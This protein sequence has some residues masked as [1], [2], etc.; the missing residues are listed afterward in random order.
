MKGTEF[1]RKLRKLGKA[2][3]VPV[4]YANTR[5][6]GRGSHGK[7][8]YRPER[9]ILK[10]PKKELGAGLLGKMCADLGIDKNDL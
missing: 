5:S 9:T 7:V 8:S 4:S 10:D 3:G 2:N 6:T 1:L